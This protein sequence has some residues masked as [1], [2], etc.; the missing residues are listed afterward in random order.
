MTTVPISPDW[1]QQHRHPGLLGNSS[2]EQ[3]YLLSSDLVT[4][5][6]SGLTRDEELCV[7]LLS[8][9]R[10]I[11]TLTSSAPVPRQRWKF[12]DG[13][14]AECLQYCK[15]PQWWLQLHLGVLWGVLHCLRMWYI[16]SGLIRTVKYHCNFLFICRRIIIRLLCQ[17]VRC[18]LSVQWKLWRL[19]ISEQHLLQSNNILTLVL[20]SSVQALSSILISI[21]ARALTVFARKT[22][23]HHHSV[24]GI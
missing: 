4:S 19:D 12:Q 10:Y 13:Q 16:R 21:R 24:P 6:R 17:W 8:G 2:W 14:T 20:T 18:V 22:H 3:L 9:S 23:H 5:P 7:L 11:S 15:V 1:G